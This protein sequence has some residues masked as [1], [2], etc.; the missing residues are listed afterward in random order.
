MTWTAISKDDHKEMVLKRPENYEFLRSQILVAICNFELA[1]CAPWLPIVFGKENG[2]IRPFALM[3]L[4]AGKNLLINAKGQWSLNFLPSVFAAH[5]FR[6]GKGKDDKSV[7]VFFDDNTFVTSDAEGQ[8]LFNEDGSESAVFNHYIQLLSK[9]QTSNQQLEASCS[10]LEQSAIL[11]PFMIEVAADGGTKTKL[12]GL[13]KINPE[14]F[15]ALDNNQFIEMREQ[16][17]LELIYAHL[18]SMGGLARLEQM[19][20]FS[21]MTKQSL[22]ELGTKIFEDDKQELKLDFN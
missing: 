19:R 16:N 2:K 20:K 7:V 3:G 11:Q 6:I 14:K 1:S 9:I 22:G 5:P 17:T 8:R 21:N 13:L 10:V 15:K 4:E 12:E 18:F